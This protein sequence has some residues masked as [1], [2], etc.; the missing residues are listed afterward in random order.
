[1]AEK[2]EQKKQDEPVSNTLIGKLVMA[3]RLVKAVAKDGNNQRQGYSFQSEAA[4]K[5][6]VK[7]A[8]N[9]VGIQII[10]DY[11]VLNQYDRQTNKGGTIHFVDVMGHFE[12]TDGVEHIGGSMPGSGQDTGE[13]AMMKATT[14]SQKYF[15]KQLFNISDRDTDPDSD[16]SQPAGGF[17][18]VQQPQTQ[19]H[20]APQQQPPMQQ[21]PQLASEMDVKV[22][23]QMAF[24]F[25]QSQNVN[26]QTIF[27]SA[28]LGAHVPKKSFNQ[29]TSDELG[30]LKRA[31]AQ[32]MG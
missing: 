31:L 10:P 11:E 14:A 21:A 17:Q 8:I 5:D 29:V 6:A 32:L 22:F 2:V 20:Q 12:I 1:M 9:T 25:A 26:V 3:S 13:K 24:D 28:F 19:Y 27:A 4:I 30:L 18:N 16:D 15:Y 7:S 23:K